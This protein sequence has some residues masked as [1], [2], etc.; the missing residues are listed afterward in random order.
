MCAVKSIYNVGVVPMTLRNRFCRA[1][2]AITLATLVATS[3][4]G[5]VTTRVVA[6]GGAGTTTTIAP[7]ASVSI[8]IRLDVGKLLTAGTGL[9]GTSFR[10]R[11]PTPA[12]NGFFSITARSFAGSPFSDASS[13]TSDAKVLAPPGNA[14][15]PDNGE[16]LGRTT[17]NLAASAPAVNTLAANLTLT[18]SVK[19][20]PGTYTINL[21]PGVSFATDDAFNAYDMSAGAPFTII[22][23][24]APPPPK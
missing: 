22:V 12:S 2:G 19:T 3:A 20:P 15:K 6:A 9:I 24:G 8:D 23:T 1:L 11:Q 17:V 7:G 4:I 18:A 21:T 5:A 16:N 13:G 10:I 14:L